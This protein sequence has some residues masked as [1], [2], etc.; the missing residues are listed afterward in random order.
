L[1][2]DLTKELENARLVRLMMKLGFINER[3]EWVDGINFSRFPSTNICFTLQICDG[4]QMVRDGRSL[5][6]EAFQGLRFPSG[7]RER[8]AGSGYGARH[9]LPQQGLCKSPT[10]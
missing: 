8:K 6:V 4:P 7:G 3:P 2:S 9:F 5:F 1:E 10:E